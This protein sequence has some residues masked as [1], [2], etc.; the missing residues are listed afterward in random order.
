MRVAGIK[1]RMTAPTWRLTRGIDYR[2]LGGQ[3]TTMYCGGTDK[4]ET[5]IW[6]GGGGSISW[7]DYL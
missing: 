5:T 6:G 2:R 4:F 1:I 3:Q 7:R